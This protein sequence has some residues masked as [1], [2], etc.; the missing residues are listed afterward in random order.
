[1]GAIRRPRCTVSGEIL[2]VFGHRQVHVCVQICTR[3]R[4]T[5]VRWDFLGQL[6]HAAE[7]AP[8]RHLGSEADRGHRN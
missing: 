4:K 1:M 2:G 3:E 7:K 8:S 6:P 5:L